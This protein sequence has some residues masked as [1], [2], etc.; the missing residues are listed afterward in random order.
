MSYLRFSV[1]S[2][3]VPISQ[4]VQ[5]QGKGDQVALRKRSK[6]VAF[7]VDAE[8]SVEEE[9]TSETPVEPSKKHVQPEK[10]GT[11]FRLIAEA[12]AAEAGVTV[13]P[14]QVPV[15]K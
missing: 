15:K 14:V 5:T 4:Y 8:G 10:K 3:K 7:D 12:K 13:A 2:P 11:L 1:S 9:P 6:P